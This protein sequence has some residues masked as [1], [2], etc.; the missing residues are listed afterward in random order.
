MSVSSPP[1]ARGMARTIGGT[2]VAKVFVMGLSGLIG[3]FTSRL[4]IEHFGTAAYAQY[5]L[6]SSFPGLL[7]FADLGIAAV[8]INVIA[9]SAAPRD[10]LQVRRTITTALRILLVSGSI[11]ILV[12]LIITLLGAWPTLLGNGLLP[13]GGSL[14]A[15]LCLVVFGIALPLTVG[16]RI[17][18]ALQK[19]TSQVASQAVVAPFILLSIVTLIAISAPAGSFIAVLSYI[20]NGLVSVICLVI[21]AR[22]LSPQ[23][24]LAFRDVF[25]I[26]TVKG[27][28]VIGLAWP[29]LLQMV[30]LP[31]SMQTDRL[32]LSHLTTGEQLAQYNLASQLFGIILQTIAAAGLALWPF[33]ARARSAS[34][35]ESPFAPTLWFLG[36]GLVLGLLLVAVSPW[37]THFVAGN[38]I[39]L[40]GWLLFSFVVFVALQAAKYPIGMYMT[41]KRGLVFQVVPIVLMIPLNLGLS[42]ALIGVLGAAGTVIGSAVAVLLC[43][44][45]PNF[46]YVQRDIRKRREAAV[47]LEVTGV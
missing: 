46:I 12:A 37:I 24:R 33:Y 29:M 30:A 3:I 4:I 14:A 25:R 17:L 45:V 36:G 20:G 38:K 9:G 16:Q 27:V 10:D 44:V 19:T 41:D 43:Q 47:E 42:W 15:F 7:P 13:Q 23:M 35:V 28:G 22:A 6:L 32:L 39:S 8:V 1:R 11:I 18:V 2:A 34:R 21:A 40:D 31:I 26:R 5:G